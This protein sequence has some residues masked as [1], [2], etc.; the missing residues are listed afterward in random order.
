M[1]DNYDT[2]LIVYREKKRNELISKVR[3]PIAFIEEEKYRR[4]WHMCFPYRKKEKIFENK[5][6]L[7][8]YI[9]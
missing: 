3:L 6:T 4:F 1:Y 8:L 9:Y 7:Y 5:F 2:M